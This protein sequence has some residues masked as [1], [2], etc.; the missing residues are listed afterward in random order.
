M[1]TIHP[2]AYDHKK[3]IEDLTKA[4]KDI[5]DAPCDDDGIALA[6]EHNARDVIF[7]AER[8]LGVQK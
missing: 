1:S 5:L 6:Y 3:L 7:R 8:M 2:L 4:L